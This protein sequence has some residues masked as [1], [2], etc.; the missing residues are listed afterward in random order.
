MQRSRSIS[1]AIPR[2][3]CTPKLKLDEAPQTAE[4]RS[5]QTDKLAKVP[6]LAV[7]YRMPPRGSHDAVVAAVAGEITAQ[8]P[9][10]APLSEP[11]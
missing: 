4:R 8:R 11:W 3:G 9:G 10:L 6:A 1:A 5:I 2:R 7:G